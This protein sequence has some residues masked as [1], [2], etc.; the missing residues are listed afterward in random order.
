MLDV[1]RLFPDSHP[2]LLLGEL[3]LLKPH[4]YILMAAILLGPARTFFRIPS[5]HIPLLFMAHL[6][7]S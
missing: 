5:L 4:L 3:T 1:L 7:I 2:H 6:D